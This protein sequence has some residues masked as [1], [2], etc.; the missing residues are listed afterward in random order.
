MPRPPDFK[1]D[2]PSYLLEKC[3]ESERYLIETIVTL[4]KKADWQ[5][6]R[7]EKQDERLAE[8][9]TMLGDILIQVKTTNGRLI[10]AE[11]EIGALKVTVTDMQKDITLFDTVLKLLS[12]K[13]FWIAFL[14]GA[15]IFFLGALPWVYSNHITLHQLIQLIV[16]FAA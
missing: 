9:R 12:N 11:G 8:D 7:M 1:S 16:K 13:W 5:T 14:S 2:I 4:S 10:K 3:S 6:A 15:A